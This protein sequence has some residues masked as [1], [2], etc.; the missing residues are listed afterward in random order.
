MNSAFNRPLKVGLL[1]Y[2]LIAWVDIIFFL[3]CSVG[4]YLA[5]QYGPSTF[6]WVFILMGVYMLMSSGM[7]EL[8]EDGVSHKN[9]VGQYRMLWREVQRIE[10]GTQGSL[11]LHGEGKRF[12]LVPASFWSGPDKVEAFTLLDR[13]VKELA[14]TPYPSNVADYKVH[15][16]VKVQSIAV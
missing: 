6:F 9:V 5:G 14:I 2:K 12:V 16:N 11:V 1:S 4:A 10:M 15:K 7:F 13:K 8:D 3:G